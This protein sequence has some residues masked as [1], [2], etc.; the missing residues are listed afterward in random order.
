MKK[1]I[2]ILAI[3][4]LGLA[5]LS[6]QTTISSENKESKIGWFITPEVSAMFLDD[7]VGNAVGASFGLSFWKN[8]IKLGIS[9]YG[10]SGPI[11]GTTFNIEADNGQTYKGSNTL[12]LRA[13]HGTFAVF[14]APTFKL[15]KVQLDV[16]I[17][18]GTIGAGFY[19]VGDDRITP[20]GRRV[21]EW[22]NQMMDGRDAG[23]GGLLEVGARAFFPTKMK[24][25]QIG[26]GLHFTTTQGWETYFDPTGNFYNNKLRAS[27][28]I[29]F[30]T[31]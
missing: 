19:F 10:R 8:R 1:I 27:L 7:H 14:I 17:S 9:G 18:Y 26:A 5:N 23:F 20:D 22:E 13:D 16:P 21:S 15:G 12:T 29:N 31:P 25:M 6:A 3:G 24:G 4:F 11:N 28:F 30:G 2:I